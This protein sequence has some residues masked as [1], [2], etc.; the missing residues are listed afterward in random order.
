MKIYEKRFVRE[1]RLIRGEPSF[2][3]LG[4]ADMGGAEKDIL[5][6]INLWKDCW[7]EI[8]IISIGIKRH[9]S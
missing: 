8:K 7:P 6:D 1:A 9:F 5:K 3:S 2:D 4:V